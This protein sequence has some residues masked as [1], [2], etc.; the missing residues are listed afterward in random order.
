MK[1]QIYKVKDS[2]ISEII[3]V[4][5]DTS[6]DNLTHFVPPFGSPEIILYIGQTHQIKNV[7][8]ANGAIKGQYNISQKIDFIPN[9]HFLNIRL[10]PYGLKQLFNINATELLNSVIDIENHP[11][12][13]ALVGF[14]KSY[15]NLDVLFLKTLISYIEQFALHPISSSTRNFVK[16]ASQKEF[17][18]IKD[19][20]FENNTGLRTLQRNFKKEVGLLPK[21]Y[22]RIKRMNSVE[23]KLSQNVSVFDI[24][25]DFGFSDQSHYIKEFKQ[26]RNFTPNEFLKKKMLLSDQLD[27]PE[28]II[29]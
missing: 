2:I 3:E 17:K 11:I 14:F 13:E 10:Q 18:T 1:V 29:I 28:I 9:Y 8:F 20:A 22:L 5:S 4:K 21:E 19:I 26:L 24:I 7:P 25:A 12:T 6:T 27:V 15:D 23:Q 16:L